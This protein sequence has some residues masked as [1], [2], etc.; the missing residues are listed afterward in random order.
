ML[1]KFGWIKEYEEAAVLVLLW[2]RVGVTPVGVP[3]TCAACLGVCMGVTLFG[4][5]DTLTVVRR[6]CCGY[7]WCDGVIHIVWGRVGVTPLE[8]PDTSGEEGMPLSTGILPIAALN[9][10][11]ASWAK[12]RAGG[13]PFSTGMLPLAALD[14]LGAASSWA[15]QVGRARCRRQQQQAAAASSRLPP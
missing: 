8:V 5:P 7:Y 3:D 15:K 4:A 6:G 13:V 9:L 2:A 11:A 10:G 14:L 12:K 1:E